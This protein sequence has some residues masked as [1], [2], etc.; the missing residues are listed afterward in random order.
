LHLNG[1]VGHRFWR[2]L[3]WWWY[4]VLPSPWPI[5]KKNEGDSEKQ[6]A[7]TTPFQNQEYNVRNINVKNTGTVGARGSKRV[8]KLQR[9]KCQ[10]K[11]NKRSELTT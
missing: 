7:Y 8:T 5:R 4:Q 10:T 9:W 2:L 11:E 3:H 1:I 6:G